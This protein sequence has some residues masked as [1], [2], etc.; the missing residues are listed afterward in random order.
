[1]M[2]GTREWDEELVRGWA[3]GYTVSLQR[4]VGR[5]ETSLVIWCDILVWFFSCFTWVYTPWAIAAGF[6][7]GG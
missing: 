5:G 7:R 1:M 6:Q 4:P 3:A 2:R